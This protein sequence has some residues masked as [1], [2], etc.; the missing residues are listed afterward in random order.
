M[1]RPTLLL[2]SQVYVPDPTRTG[3]LMHDAAV[4]MVGR[5]YR[6]VVL[7]S[8]R[9]YDDPSQKYVR[10]EVVDGVEV[11]RLPLSSFGKRSIKTRLLAQAWFLVQVFLRGVF[12]R[13]LKVVLVGTSPPM[14]SIAAV[15]ISILRRVSLKYW[16]LDL[17]P[18]LIIA[19]GVVAETSIAA[20][21]FHWIDRRALACAND[22]ITLDDFMADR[23]NAKV[24]CSAKMTVIPPWPN[25]HD[26]EIVEHSTNAFREKHCF[27][28]GANGKL[29]IMYSG[30]HG[31]SNPLSTVI[32]A[33]KRLQYRKDI[34]FMF[35]GGGVEK[36]RVE[37]AIS[38]GCEN[39]RSLPFQPSRD[40]RFSLSAADVHVVSVENAVVGICHPCKMYGAMAVGRPLFLI[41]P[42]PC[43]ASEI[44]KGQE[45]GWHVQ[46][47]DVDGALEAIKA[48]VSLPREELSAMG[49]NAQRLVNERFSKRLLLPRF[50]DVLEKGIT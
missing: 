30:N 18:D 36:K 8:A 19:L 33:A 43:H 21:V 28:A 38:E 46:Q 15:P 25:E 44:M 6:V 4:E 49:I 7:T 2:I 37:T 45:I 11:R 16:Q 42:N 22:V 39:I 3:H 48:M 5:G 41:G 35:I 9:G 29:V 27:G 40:L 34:V 13:N 14:A 23:L 1:R 26:F 10:R 50:C 20:R 24:D 17:N 12:T 31:P 47:G 32:A